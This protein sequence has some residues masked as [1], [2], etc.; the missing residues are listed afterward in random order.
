MGVT[1][2]AILLL[3]GIHLLSILPISHGF[4]EKYIEFGRA[5]SANFDYINDYKKFLFELMQLF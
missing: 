5:L 2:V 1:L 4:Q 3:F